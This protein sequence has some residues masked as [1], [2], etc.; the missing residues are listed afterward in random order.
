MPTATPSRRA[1]LVGTTAAV[2][3]LAAMT[4]TVTGCSRESPA[5]SRSSCTTVTPA[6]NID[7]VTRVIDLGDLVTITAHD[8]EPALFTAEGVSA[9]SVGELADAVPE[10][11]DGSSW[12]VIQVDDEGFESEV[13]LS[14]PKGEL[15]IVKM[16]ETDCPERTAITITISK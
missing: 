4:M 6:L 1:R 3:T 7:A 15:G 5:P 2:A 11:F 9:R 8:V 14:G 10:Q 16:R 13:Y 12:D